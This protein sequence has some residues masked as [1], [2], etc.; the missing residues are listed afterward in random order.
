MNTLGS[1]GEAYNGSKGILWDGPRAPQGSHGD[2]MGSILGIPGFPP[3]IPRVPPRDRCVSP[4]DPWGEKVGKKVEK[5][6]KQV[7]KG[8]EGWQEG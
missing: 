5:V 7:E 4:R 8:E 3:G 1:S 2:P 6:G